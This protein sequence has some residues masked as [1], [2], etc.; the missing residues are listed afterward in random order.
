MA[1][2]RPDILAGLPAA[3]GAEQMRPEKDHE[4]KYEI[5]HLIA[6]PALAER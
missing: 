2:L 3:I 5:K 6:S 4:T 1:H